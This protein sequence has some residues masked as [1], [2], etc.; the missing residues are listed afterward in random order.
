MKEISTDTRLHPDAS[1]PIEIARVICI[2][3]MIFVHVNPA[4]ADFAPGTHGVRVFDWARFFVVDSFGRAS[5]ALLSVIAGYLAVFAL[6][7]VDYRA[8]LG[9]RVRSLLVPLA[10]WSGLF[11]A[12]VMVGDHIQPGYLEKTVGRALTLAE[13]PTLL[14]AA[15]D[16][17]ANL[18]LAFLRDVFVCALLAPV[19]IEAWKRGAVVF[20]AL[21]S[22]LYALGMV[23]PFLLTP[24]LLA[25]YAVGI[26][27]ACDGR[28]PRIPVWIA[29]LSWA[30]FLGLGV[31]IAA[32]EMRYEAAPD[33][34]LLRQLEIGL[35]LIRLPAAIA[36]WSLSV[37]LTTHSLGLRM[38]RLER[39]IFTAFC[40]HMLI[41]S[42]AWF[43]WQTVFGG[44]YGPL[45]PVFFFAAPIVVI[46]FAA[47]FAEVASRVA[48]PVFAVLNGGRAL[49]SR[50]TKS[51][52]V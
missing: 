40:A 24:N 11:L 13:L 31:A 33:A 39:Y 21:V 37:W 18:P 10:L 19:L 27:I 9:K 17:P 22:A 14:L 47:V 41:L 52:A 36:F 50:N 30:V 29:A 48:G 16:R 7:R 44:Y 1:R 42:A 45:Y 28:L 49:G 3:C 2:A 32:G 15:L 51:V 12:M 34:A 25:F 35:T 23:T 26:W 8:F 46:A 5:V 38:A 20:V 4:T 43:A 6:R